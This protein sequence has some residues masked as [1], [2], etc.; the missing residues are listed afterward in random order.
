[1][2]D[3]NRHHNQHYSMPSF[4]IASVVS[5][6]PAGKHTFYY[7]DW[8]DIANPKVLL[9]L[10]GLVRAADDFDFLAEELRRDYR[11]ICPDLVGRGRSDRLRDPQHYQV[12]QYAQDIV[13]LLSSL[14]LSQVDVLGTSLGALVGMV[15]A[16]LPGAVVRRLILNDASPQLHAEGMRALGTQIARRLQFSSFEEAAQHVRKISA[17]QGPHSDSQWQTLARNALRKTA[18]NTWEFHY[19]PALSVPLLAATEESARLGEQALWE[20]Y[21]AISCPTLLIRGQESTLLS[22]EIAA[23]MTRRGPQAEL[24]QIAGVGHAPTFLHAD[25]VAVVRHFLLR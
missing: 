12:G 18:E 6:S 13:A 5:Q 10:H 25:Q 16:T 8:G 15:L 7:K 22:A 20:I 23:S 4:H 24:A 14:Q 21:D 2:I 3:I 1:M 19:D 17:G 11:I 9:C